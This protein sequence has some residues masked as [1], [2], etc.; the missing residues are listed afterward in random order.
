[1]RF[2]RVLEGLALLA[3]TVGMSDSIGQN[4]PDDRLQLGT[5]DFPTSGSVGAQEEFI[6][7]VLALHSF[8]Y[9]E[10]RGHFLAAQQID[11][12]FGMAY[13]GEAMTY[14]NALHTVQG[15]ENEFLGTEAATRLAELDAAG[16]LEWT[17][18]ERAL[19]RRLIGVSGIGPKLARV[20]LSGMQP[21]DLISAIAGQDVT[22]LTRTPGVGKKTAERIVLEL[23]DG[24]RTLAEELPEQDL[25]SSED[26]DVTEALMSLGYKISVASRAV[27]STREEHPDAGFAELLRAALS[28]LSRA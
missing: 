11:P 21:G 9:D 27:V 28:R 15:E 25:P 20:I 12:R 13:W 23:K 19:F 8:W 26:D 6:T 2:T 7:G 5:I 14:D 17:E 3:L 22:R 18:R 16:D 4:S 24:M 10:A 1:M